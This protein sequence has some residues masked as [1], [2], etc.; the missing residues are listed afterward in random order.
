[1]QQRLIKASLVLFCHDQHPIFIGMEGCR[2]CFFLDGLTC[3]SGVEFLL[4]I[5]DAVV[6]HFPR[7]GHQNIQVSVAFFFDLTFELK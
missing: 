4:G 7:E 3:F 1:M 6:L 5:G 2:E